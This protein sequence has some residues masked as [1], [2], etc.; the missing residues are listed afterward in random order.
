MNAE[1]ALSR[2]ESIAD[3][4]AAVGM[5]AQQKGLSIACAESLTSGAIASAL[6]RAPH[7]ALWF[8]GGVVAYSET[9]KVEVLGVQRGPVVTEQC[10]IEMAAGVRRL[11]QADAAVAVTGVRGP[12]ELE[13]H[14]PGTVMIAVSSLHRDWAATHHFDGDPADVVSRTTLHALVRLRDMLDV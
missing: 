9:A 5:V 1:I 14:A 13:G 12:G 11:M 10:A 3:E 8:S 4:A 6:G 2:D 7:S